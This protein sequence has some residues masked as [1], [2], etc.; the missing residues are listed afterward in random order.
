VALGD[1]SGRKRILRVGTLL[2]MSASLRAAF[3]P[4]AG[5]LIMDTL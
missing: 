4:A 1:R 5:V 3:A 2:A